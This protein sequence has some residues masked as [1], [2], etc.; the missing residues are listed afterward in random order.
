MA[1]YCRYCNNFV[2]GNGDY[3]EKKEICMTEKQAK[4]T[5][6]CKDFELNEIDAYYENLR[7][8]HPRKN[9][10]TRHKAMYKVEQINIYEEQENDHKT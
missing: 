3:C 8:Y 2:T 4:R 10:V 9:K 6:K 1:Q 5:N 7:G